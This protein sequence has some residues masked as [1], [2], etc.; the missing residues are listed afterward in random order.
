MKV[1]FPKSTRCLEPFF[2]F[3]MANLLLDTDGPEVGGDVLID[4]KPK[5]SVS[6]SLRQ[7]A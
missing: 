1:N 3:A 6:T 4:F 5:R 7:V 2:Y